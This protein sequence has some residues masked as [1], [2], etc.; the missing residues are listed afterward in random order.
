MPRFHYQVTNK[1]NRQTE[2]I[3]EAENRYVAV[4]RLLH[5]GMHITEIRELTEAPPPV[6]AGEYPTAESP[7]LRDDE[8]IAVADGMTEIVRGGLPLA[9]GLRALATE[10]PSRRVRRALETISDRLE[11][12]VAVDEAVGGQIG[13]VPNHLRV[14]LQA[15]LQTGRATELLEHYLRF[16]RSSLDVRRRSLLAMTYPL[17]LL[18][19]TTTVISGMLSFVV[20]KFKGLLDGYV[21]SFGVEMSSLTLLAFDL[22]DAMAGWRILIPVLVMALFITTWIAFGWLAG[23]TQRKWLYH[24]PAIGRMIRLAAASRFCHLLAIGIAH[25]VPFPEALRSA[26]TGASDAYIR[27]ATHGMATDIEKGMPPGQAATDHRMVPEVAHVFE[28]D[29]HE[30]EFSDVLWATGD[31]CAIQSHGQ[32]RLIGVLVQPLCIFGIAVAVSLIVFA[33]MLPMIN[34]MNAIF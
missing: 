4:A 12:G 7:R 17:L 30:Q 16:A 31:I 6:E 10:L 33:L 24:V 20:P 18:L 27:R 9:S 8:L 14:L 1:E 19:L 3:I 2:G 34:L 22:A 21:D 13:N 32:S 26:G 15:S 5:D 29:G 23:A 25:G 11:Q 28:W